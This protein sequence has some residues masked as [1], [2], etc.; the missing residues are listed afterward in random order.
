VVA[1]VGLGAVLV[2]LLLIR[3][4]APWQY[5][6]D[7]NGAWY[8]AVARAHLLKGLGQTRGQDFFVARTDGRLVPYLHHP[9]LLGLY[10]AGV[11]RLSGRDTPAVA[12][13]AMAALHLLSYALFVALAARLLP[14][15][16]AAQLWAALVFAVVPLSGFFGKM[17]NHEGPALFF[18]LG[19][20]L[21][22]IHAAARPRGWPAW[23]CLGGLAL[24]L[25]GFTAWHALAAGTG[26]AAVLVFSRRP[27]ER[28]TAGYIGAAGL[29]L[30]AVLVPL[31]MR[32][33]N[34]GR[35]LASQGESA[36]HWMAFSGGMTGLRDYVGDL[37][38]AFSY[39][40]QYEGLLPTLLAVAWLMQAG[41][42]RLRGEPLAAEETFLAALW[43]GSFGY[44]LGFA[45][46]A[47]VHPYQQMLLLPFVALASARVVGGIAAA[48]APRRRLRLAALVFLAAAT[49]GASAAQYVKLYRKPSPAAL[50]RAADIQRQYY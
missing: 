28:V 41:W 33:A 2:A 24:L 37:L 43:A 6:N 10:L 20:A 32:W 1:V 5:Q 30:A 23:A 26:V 18:L 40:C 46:L 11:F 19:G 8:S 29:V 36:R 7:D 14:G 13:L 42:R 47:R 16:R 38:H 21:A 45:E 48:L 49:L 50:A 34:H 31:H 4:G 15:R 12:R 22:L 39:A 9:P 17:P 25:A 3:I 27:C 35:W 44:Q